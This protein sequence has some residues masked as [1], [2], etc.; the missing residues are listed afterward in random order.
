MSK[1]HYRPLPDSLT[2]KESGLSSKTGR[3]E[4]GLFTTQDIPKGTCLG[5][6]HYYLDFDAVPD[7]SG[8]SHKIVCTPLGGFINHSEVPNCKLLQDITT[9]PV[10]W[11]LHT[12]NDIKKNEELLLT[13]TQYNP[14]TS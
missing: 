5:I 9:T 12:L 2:I 14:E 13:Y 3:R 8:D 10:E 1:E 6:T 7:M 11:Q 4:L